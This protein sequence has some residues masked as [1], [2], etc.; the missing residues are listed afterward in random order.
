MDQLL[1]ATL[2]DEQI[3]EGLGAVTRMES[4]P[5]TPGRPRAGRTCGSGQPL[6]EGLRSGCTPEPFP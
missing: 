5:Y 6:R 4:H 2:V 1:R 3:N